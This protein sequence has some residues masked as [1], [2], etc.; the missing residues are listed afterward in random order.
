MVLS[1]WKISRL[2][3]VFVLLVTIL[4]AA[5]CAGNTPVSGKVTVNNK[6]LTSGSVRYVPDKD[7][8]NTATVEPV[9]TISESGTYELH[10]NGQP[11]PPAG[12]Y[13][14]AV[15]AQD[16]VDNTKPTDIKTLIDSK[17]N[18]AEKTDLHVEVKSGAAPGAY[19]LKLDG[20]G[21]PDASGTP[22]GTIPMPK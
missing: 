5:G 20:P 1:V 14:V 16:K 6:P 19:D 10:T 8:G 18:T 2:A 17:Y 21:G 3:L 4:T 15:V 22:G 9:G 13:K 7:K 12:F 11:G